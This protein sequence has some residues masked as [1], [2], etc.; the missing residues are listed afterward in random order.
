MFDLNVLPIFLQAGKD[1]PE[2]PG[3]FVRT[4]PKKCDRSR[5]GDTLTALIT[6][7][8]S[9]PLETGELTAWMDEIAT[10]Y[11]S[12]RGSATMGLRAAAEQLNKL[13]MKR[14]ISGARQGW[15]ALALLNL[16]VLRKDVLYILHAGPTHT[17]LLTQNTV[18]DFVDES[19]GN[20]G[21]GVSQSATLRYFQANVNSNSLMVLCPQAPDNWK[22]IITAGS[23]IS[24]GQL[25]RRLFTQS[26][27]ELRA[28]AIQFK[29]GSGEIHFKRSQSSP[30]SESDSSPAAYTGR[31][32]S[33]SSSEKGPHTLES[34]LQSSE[35]S[36][37][38]A[39][40]P[41]NDAVPSRS[42]P[43]LSSTGENFSSNEGITLSG[44]RLKS[45][46]SEKPF[47]DTSAEEVIPHR[48][49]SFV[50]EE[51]NYH[52]I[53]PTAPQHPRGPSLRKRLATFW[54]GSQ[55]AR[56][57]FS[58]NSRKFAGQVLPGSQPAGLTTGTM[59]F[60]AIAIPL[61]IAVIAT[62]VYFRSGRGEQYRLFLQ[63][64]QASAASA[65][66]Q[67]DPNLS[68]L[69][70]EKTIE[71]LDQAEKYGKTDDS[72]ALRLKAQQILDEAEGITRLSFQPAMLT[73]FGS[74]VKIIRMDASE[75]DVYLLDGTRGEVLR[76]FLTGQ[77]FDVD[78][79]FECGPGPSGSLLI[80]PLIDV[81]AL[82]PNSTIKATALAMD[83]S[84]NL[85]LC[86]P[87]KSPLSNTLATPPNGWGKIKAFT[88]YQQ[89]LY[90]LDAGN[91]AVWYY[92]GTDTGFSD[93]PRLFFDNQVPVLNNAIDLAV[94]GEDLFILRDNNQML[95]CT[96]RT[97][98]FGQTKCE[99]PSKYGD[100]RLGREGQNP[101]FASDYAFNQMV[102]TL[103]PDPSL[104]VLDSGHN[105]IVH[106]SLRLNLQR[107]LQIKPDADFPLPDKP[108]TAFTM[109]PNRGVLL[110]IENELYY[111]QL[112]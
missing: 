45:I 61:V 107:Y 70:W 3:L 23:T 34:P 74:N 87:G 52:R 26:N 8:G 25:I 44:E 86:E 54:F 106:F 82:P 105:Q 104:Y 47:E 11:Y 16:I 24:P 66:E 112:P 37:V 110:A 59:L 69:G 57:R 73:S 109:T 72:N 90:V 108:S 17:L 95:H 38:A 13:V 53:K 10:A 89:N 31:T 12:A 101:T 4:A 49:E 29:S 41:L 68:R 93:Q 30:V 79:Q 2:L 9:A 35:M 60:I 19:G 111:A 91:N 22:T 32:S 55:S 28:V 88:I 56:D 103:P 15:Q 62:T 1:Q 100:G 98:S 5:V 67:Q 27:G 51:F 71:Y 58:E 97:F 78:P 102:T 76:L 92:E 81:V 7:T 43:P 42:V 21:L 18:E 80:G 83:G 99:D 48:T 94:N 50:Q 64:A 36:T 46:P 77:G 85:M 20:Y 65:V 33:G 40:L 75:T 96:F 63:K 6:M 84:G 14:N 39:P